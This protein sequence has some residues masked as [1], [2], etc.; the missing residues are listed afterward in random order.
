MNKCLEIFNK[1]INIPFEKLGSIG[2]Y[3]NSSSR[4][5]QE[6]R[7]INYHGL[8]IAMSITDSVLE[9]ELYLDDQGCQANLSSSVDSDIIEKFNKYVL[10]MQDYSKNTALEYFNSCIDKFS[11][12]I[13]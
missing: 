5:F 1:V 4:T 6:I 13:E 7:D 2:L 9:I 11:E 8:S 10:D 12:D 3:M